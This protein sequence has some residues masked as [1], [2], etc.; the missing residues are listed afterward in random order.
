M[1]LFK[2]NKD[3]DSTIAVLGVFIAFLG[4]ISV[5]VT[6]S[7]K[8]LPIDDGI[9]TVFQSIKEL[10]LMILSY[11]FTKAVVRTQQEDKQP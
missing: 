7:L 6:L 11:F 1:G 3:L 4:T 2:D 5:M 10:V 8:R 9:L